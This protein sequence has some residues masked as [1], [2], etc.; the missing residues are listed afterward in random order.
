MLCS[1]KCFSV[2]EEV[3]ALTP[4]R[5]KDGDVITMGSTELLVHIT[6]SDTVE[7]PESEDAG[8]VLNDV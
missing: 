3:E 7:Q 1:L 6:D 5:L 2:S 8:I 4:L